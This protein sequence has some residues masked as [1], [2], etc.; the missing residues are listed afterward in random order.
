MR[1][2]IE[3]DVR[4]I[5]ADRQTRV[6]EVFE[7]WD[8]KRYRYGFAGASNLDHGKMGVAEAIIANHT[9][10]VVQEAAAVGATK[11]KATLGATL[12]AAG[13]YNDGY[14]TVND[15]A[16]EGI[17]YEIKSHGAV[18][19]AGIITVRL[20]NNSPLKIALTTAS[21]VSLRPSP[22]ARV[23]VAPGAIAHR[24]VGVPNVDIT[25]AY[26]GWFQ[27]RGDCSVLSDGVISKGAGA[28]LSDAV[29]GALEIEVAA[30]VVGR[31]GRAPE[32]TVDTEYRTITLM[33]E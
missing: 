29:N 18:L 19:S 28:I 26:Y 23:I 32:A 15:S 3:Q 8:G 21:E 33:V 7:T 5:S 31:V 10:I 30:S 20:D 12:A 27:T 24:P 1:Q 2:T 22:W 9:N 4:S 17:E 6:G 13:F 14:L 16:G 25:A 11:V